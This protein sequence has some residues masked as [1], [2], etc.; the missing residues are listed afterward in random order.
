MRAA[1]WVMKTHMGAHGGTWGHMGKLRAS[2]CTQ[3]LRSLRA[4]AGTVKGNSLELIFPLD[5]HCSL[6]TISCCNHY[7]PSA[8]N[9]HFSKC[10]KLPHLLLS[11]LHDIRVPS[12]SQV[13]FTLNKFHSSALRAWPSAMDSSFPF[14]TLMFTRQWL[15]TRSCTMR[16]TWCCHSA[17]LHEGTVILTPRHT[18]RAAAITLPSMDR[19]ALTLAALMLSP[20]RTS[21]L[22]F[23]DQSWVSS[24]ALI[25]LLDM[26]LRDKNMCL[27][28][29][30]VAR[31]IMKI[32]AEW[33]K[34]NN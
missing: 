18:A 28:R 29:K 2:I 11:Q 13:I 14:T 8:K 30:Q 27:R 6:A 7:K 34:M 15:P 22:T 20:P 9:C 10:I 3:L 32:W 23:T 12:I 17:L 24:C 26:M 1:S 19:S 25:N 16:A 31:K 21:G 4:I 33:C 5:S